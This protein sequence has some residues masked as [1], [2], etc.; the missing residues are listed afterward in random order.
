[1]Q[2]KEKQAALVAEQ[3]RAAVAGRQRSRKAVTLVVGLVAVLAIALGA[4]A[5]ALFG[6]DDGGASEPSKPVIPFQVDANAPPVVPNP[7]VDG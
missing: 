7:S 1:M 3:K 6:G 5:I 4:L 2:I